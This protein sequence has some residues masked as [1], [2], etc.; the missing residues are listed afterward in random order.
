MIDLRKY[1]SHLMTNMEEPE[2]PKIIDGNFYGIHIPDEL[3]FQLLLQKAEKSD[4]DDDIFI[5][6][7]DE[8]LNDLVKKQIDE[9]KSMNVS[10]PDDTPAKEQ[11]MTTMRFP[12]NATKQILNE[13][14]Q[15][16]KSNVEDIYNL[17]DSLMIKLDQQVFNEC[18]KKLDSLKRSYISADKEN[19]AC[20][21]SH[22]QFFDPCLYEIVKNSLTT[23]NRELPLCSS[24]QLSTRSTLSS[25]C[26]STMSQLCNA[27][28]SM[29]TAATSSIHLPNAP[30][31]DNAPTKEGGRRK[32][33]IYLT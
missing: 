22:L 32:Y 29:M 4:D 10:L 17:F 19:L 1:N 15:R 11:A 13:E 23:G 3:K 14:M 28:T 31:S 7:E 5:N 16:K 27:A 2:N 25:A 6:V 21:M 12:I 20:I 26:S 24:S 9:R 8:H 33:K 18:M 30:S